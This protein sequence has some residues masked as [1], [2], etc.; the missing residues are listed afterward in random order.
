MDVTQST[1]TTFA[2]QYHLTDF[3]HISN[4]FQSIFIDHRGTHRHF[5][6]Q[7]FTSLAAH[8]T[9]HAALTVLR[10]IEALEF[11]IDQ[12]VKRIVTN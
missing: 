9:A 2:H 4:D 5:D 6:V 10:F 7:V 11:K 3:S 12:G 8:L 1:P